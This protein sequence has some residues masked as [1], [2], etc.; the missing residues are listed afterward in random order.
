MHSQPTP[1][2]TVRFRYVCRD[3]FGQLLESS[4]N[5]DGDE[6]TL[7]QDQLLPALEEA[8]V[9]MKPG[10]RASIHLRADQAFGAY[11]DELVAVLAEEEL[12]LDVPPSPGMIVQVSAPGEPD[13]QATVLRVD[14]DGVSIDGNHPLAGEDLVFD[15]E[16]L[17]IL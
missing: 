5:P 11:R 12:G 9:G 17:A 16:L 2:S 6:V 8:L 15:L 3:R 1:S 13:M 14:D 4:G 7:G 10:E